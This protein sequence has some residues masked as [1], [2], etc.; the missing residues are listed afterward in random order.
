M[1]PFQHLIWRDLVKAD[2]I[3]NWEPPDVLT[4]YYP[5][6]ICGYDKSGR[7]IWMEPPGYADYHGKSPRLIPCM[8]SS[9]CK[10][11]KCYHSRF[12]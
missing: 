6:D 9:Y 7:P 1:S 11:I 4:K 5:G 10:C 12:D 2:E 8:I 3:W